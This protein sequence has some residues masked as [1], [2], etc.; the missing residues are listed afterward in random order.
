MYDWF[1]IFQ[2]Q[3]LKLGMGVGQLLSK[4]WICLLPFFSTKAAGET[5]HFTILLQFWGLGH[6]TG[7]YSVE[8]LDTLIPNFDTHLTGQILAG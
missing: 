8:A 5:V 1:T 7:E 6:G 4:L 3:V 2:Y